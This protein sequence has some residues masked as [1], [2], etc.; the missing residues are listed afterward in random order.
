[1]FLIDNFF[2][3]LED[4]LVSCRKL[5]I[6]RYLRMIPMLA[7]VMEDLELIRI[8]D[9]P[10]PEVHK[11]DVLVEIRSVGVCGSDL[12][13]FHEGKM[14][15]YNV[16]FPFI[17]GHECAGVILEVGE[18]VESIVPGD[19]V[20]VE[21]GIPCRV[22]RYCKKGQY[23]ICP[24]MK[25]LGTPP[26]SGS[27]VQY[28]AFPADLV[29]KLPDQ[30]NFDEGACIEPLAVALYACR[31]GM[32][33]PGDSV[34]V[35]GLGPIGLLAGQAAKVFGAQVVV[36]TDLYS[37]RRETAKTVGIAQSFSGDNPDLAH[38]IINFLGEPPQ[39]VIDTVGSKASGELA[40]TVLDL[41]G[42]LVIVGASSENMVALNYAQIRSKELKIYGQFRYANVFPQAVKLL[43]DDA[44]K[45]KPLISKK[46]SINDVQEGMQYI[47]KNP[48][49]AIKV[50]VNM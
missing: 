6:I 12:H 2:I 13:Y 44:V 33:A 1:M 34:V 32:V 14:G 41:S 42:S 35:L 27:F 16:G 23:N 26:V 39:V 30:V 8:K 20:A 47:L 37:Y 18:E 29:Y 40:T 7:A 45:I 43:Q 10:P 24:D 15:K 50:I 38:E 4:I 22:C 11:H 36:G 5:I 3:F 48:G 49:R 25:F 46:I 19:R 9:I 17:L 21:P 31:L 28:L